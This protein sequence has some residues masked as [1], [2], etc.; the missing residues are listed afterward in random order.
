MK[1]A[2]AL[3][4]LFSGLVSADPVSP[5][6]CSQNSPPECFISGTIYPTVGIVTGTAT[7]TGA[8]TQQGAATIT[9]D[10]TYSG[11]GI[12]ILFNA[13]NENS[14]GSEAKGAKAGWFVDVDVDDDLT[15]DDDLL[16]SG[17]ATLTEG[18]L[19]KAKMF[20]DHGGTG[21]EAHIDISGSAG[22]STWRLDMDSGLE[23]LGPTD[24]GSGVSV[25]VL[26]A[27]T[28]A[29]AL[30][31]P[32]TVTGA[33]T[34]TSRVGHTTQV[35]ASAGTIAP[36]ACVVAITGSTGI[37]KITTGSY[38]AGDILFLTFDGTLTVTDGEDLALAGNFSATAGDTLFLLFDG[39]DFREVSRSNN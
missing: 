19:L 36:T 39:G 2:L 28:A 22:N 12:D 33:L 18:A 23:L 15:V 16:V 32:V 4:L 7:F 27:T 38:V 5:W 20:L 13:D 8:V 17:Q 10:Q 11:N 3:L 29:I 37:N 26:T 21:T 9:A 30:K 1:L 34:S 31:K 6:N 24:P 14:V 35:V 25:S